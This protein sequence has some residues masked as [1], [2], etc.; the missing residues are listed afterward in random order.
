MNTDLD[1]VTGSECLEYINKQIGFVSHSIDY[2]SNT[3]LTYIQQLGWSTPSGY[4]TGGSVSFCGSYGFSYLTN[5]KRW[6]HDTSKRKIGLVLGKAEGGGLE[7]ALLGDEDIFNTYDEAQHKG[8]EFTLTKFDFGVGS[9][10]T[11]S[12]V[13]QSSTRDHPITGFPKCVGNPQSGNDGVPRYCL[14]INEQVIPGVGGL[15][16]DATLDYN[17]SQHFR[18]T[19]SAQP[20]GIIW[21][22]AGALTE[23]TSYRLTSDKKNTMVFGY[24]Y[25]GFETYP[26]LYKDNPLK[27]FAGD[28]YQFACD[29]S[30]T[31]AKGI[32]PAFETAEVMKLYTT[33]FLTDDIDDSK[34][35]N[36][37]ATP[38]NLMLTYDESQ[39]LKY[40]RDG[41]IPSDAFLYPLDFD[42]LPKYQSD[43]SSDEDDDDGQGDLDDDSRDCDSDLPEVPAYT[44]NSLNTNNVYLLTAGE[45]NEIIEWLWNDVGD[46]QDLDD[47]VTKIQGL[48]SDLIQNFLMFRVMPVKPEWIGG[49]GNSTNFI[50]G[51]VEKTGQYLNLAKGNAPIVNIGSYNFGNKFNTFKFL[52]YSP[53]SDF[54]LY[55]PYH[56]IV[57]IDVSVFQGHSLDVKAVYDY[58]TGTI[59]YM[60]YSDNTWL[61]NTYTA[62]M[63]VDLSVSLQT[64][65]DRDSAIF[66]NVSNA[67]AGVMSAGASVAS[68]NPIGLVMGAQALVQQT[69]SAPFKAMGQVGEMGA[70]YTPQRCKVLIRRPVP[71]TPSTYNQNVGRQAYYS[72]TL[73][74]LKGKGYTKCINPRLKFTKTIPL[75]DEEEKINQ[76]LS[77]G[78]YL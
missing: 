29:L 8:I 14:L 54:K 24:R 45:V 10:Y 21:R 43:D 73:A 30:E 36:M 25:S 37:T 62:K 61:V 28:F 15:G 20:F 59:T 33:E 69:H 74:K 22:Y 68:G 31:A 9:T 23:G 39:A 75:A 52:N 41:T 58:M 27:C 18:S 19:G 40:L 53:Y 66:G 4:S 67:V 35:V 57:D 6:S 55:L 46:V 48:T 26:I 63:A 7:V 2:A 56:G 50:V 42:N 38:F 1:M 16:F 72:T 64:K 13:R 32:P 34:G 17:P 71:T 47:L 65:N 12:P 77:E 5:C 11:F 49:R 78:V 3:P 51:S 60:I 44:P 76:L 70:F